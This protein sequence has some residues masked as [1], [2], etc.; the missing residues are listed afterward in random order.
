MQKTIVANIKVLQ[1]LKAVLLQLSPYQYAKPLSILSQS[2]IGMHARHIIEFYVCLLAQVDNAVICYDKRERDIQLESKIDFAL[3][4]VRKVEAELRNLNA[5]KNLQLSTNTALV[6]TE[7]ESCSTSLK[8][9]LIYTMDHSIHHLA[10]IK[11][12][13][14]DN[15]PKIILSPDFG[16]APST[17]RYQTAQ[18]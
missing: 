15:Y 13:I 14:Q 8:R 9:E 4:T 3:E 2:S 17:I 12:G 18:N 7:K 16:I 11:I 10:L 1:Q 5:D 6:G